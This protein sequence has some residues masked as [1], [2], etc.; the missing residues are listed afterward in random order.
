MY[1]YLLPLDIAAAKVLDLFQGN[2]SINLLRRFSQDVIFPQFK[3]AQ[4]SV[5]I[6]GVQDEQE[7]EVKSNTSSYTTRNGSSVNVPF[8]PRNGIDL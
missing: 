2:Q 4:S 7:N 1:Y 6:P 5:S 8:H 3:A